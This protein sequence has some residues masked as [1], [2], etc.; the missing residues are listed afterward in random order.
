M[1]LSAYMSFPLLLP[2]LVVLSS[3][4]SSASGRDMAATASAADGTKPC[5]GHAALCERGYSNATF[6]G[7]HNSAFVG[8]LP[9]HNQFEPVTKQLEQGVRFLQ[10]QTHRAADSSGG[11]GGEEQQE[12]PPEIRLCHTSCLILDAGPL[13]A[14]LGDVSRWLELH[15]R[16]IVTLLLTNG[17][18][19]GVGHFAD[20]FRSAGL[21]KHVFVPAA[22]RLELAEWPT[23][24]EMLERGQRVVVFMGEFYTQSHPQTQT[25]VSYT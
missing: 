11:G 14:Y 6:V 25:S 24:G 13:D 22:A 17:D 9:V 1:R 20:A 21:E 8:A 2:V 23:L 19:I 7:S 5:N 12:G 3:A 16:D 4:L 18:G 15:P 10:A